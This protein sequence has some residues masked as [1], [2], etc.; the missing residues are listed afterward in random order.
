M[1]DVHKPPAALPTAGGRPTIFLAGSIDQGAA[2][3][4]QR[5][6]EERLIALEVARDELTDLD[7]VVLNPRRDDWDPTWDQSAD[8]GE[9]CRQV[10]WELDGLRAADLVLLYL[11]PG[12]TAPI[13]L[14]ELGLHID[15]PGLR[16]C[17]PPGFWR[18]GNVEIVCERFGVPL[19][20]DFAQFVDDVLAELTK[21]RMED[22]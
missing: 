10:E 11:A 22:T 8:A 17:C 13:S 18:R 1:V 16:V 7:L 14:L 12:S 21:R 4:W 9:F 20:H 19:W 6:I 15:H 3:D 2:V 5:V